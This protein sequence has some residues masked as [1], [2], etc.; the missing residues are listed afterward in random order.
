MVDFYVPPDKVW[1][2]RIES[3]TNQALLWATKY[4]NTM[5]IFFH[6]LNKYEP[7]DIMFSVCQVY[8]SAVK[9]AW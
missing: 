5:E 1:Y 4:T 7:C 8:I 3:C 9:P 6:L 2:T